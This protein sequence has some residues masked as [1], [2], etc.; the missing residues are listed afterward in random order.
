MDWREAHGGE[1]AGDHQHLQVRQGGEEWLQVL[2]TPDRQGLHRRACD[3]PKSH[4]SS[5][6]DLHEHSWKKEQTRGSHWK[7]PTAA[8]LSDW[9]TGLVGKGLPPWPRLLGELPAVA[10]QSGD[11]WRCGI[12][13]QGD[14]HRQGLQ[15]CW[16]ALPAQGLWLW[17]GGDRRTTRC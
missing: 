16:L 3:L 8:S 6:A 4:R 10:C 1:D 14:R 15:E 12:C 11:I 7:L 5:Q 2:R 9:F 13:E 17:Q